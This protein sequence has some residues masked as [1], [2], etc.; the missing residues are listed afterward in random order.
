MLSHYYHEEA[1][2]IGSQSSRMVS[3]SCYKRM[4]CSLGDRYVQDLLYVYGL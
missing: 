4:H 2:D 1:A 3:T